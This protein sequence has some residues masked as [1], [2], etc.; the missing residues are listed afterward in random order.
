[1]SD[2]TWQIPFSVIG[3]GVL[4]VGLLVP[5]LVLQYRRY[6]RLSVLR[7]LGAAAVSVYGV[8]LVAYTL[9][10]LPDPART[11]GEGAGRTLQLTPFQFVAD[12]AR[13]GGGLGLRDAVTSWAVLQAALN[14]VLFVPLGLA[15][16]GMLRRGVL[17]ATALGALVS[18]AIEATQ[19]TGLWGIYDCSYRIADVDDL[20]LNTTGALVGALLAPLLLHWWMPSPEQLTARRSHRVSGM[21]RL[22]GMVVDLVAVGLVGFLFDL[23]R[24]VVELVFT[25]DARQVHELGEPGQALLLVLAFAVVFALPALGR[26]G[27]SL[28]QRAVGIAPAW[29]SGA[30]G[31]GARLLRASAVGG[32]WTVGRALALLLT[33]AGIP[34]AAGALSLAIGLYMLVVLVFA[35]VGDH[36]GLSGRLAGSAM[37]DARALTD[38][39]ATARQRSAAA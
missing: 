4:F 17:T 33:A 15:V 20:I 13:E 37:V 7:L 6:G 29:P 1:M 25:T 34:L 22:L 5:I 30:G 8:A 12:I 9:L 11:C 31:V 38:A 26:S 36:R 10:P 24:A 18:L 39:G 2:W 23:G 19:Y 21:R 32:V 3:G 35:L 14:V 28:G 16:R 27:A